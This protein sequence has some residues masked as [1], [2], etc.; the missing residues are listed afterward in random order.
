MENEFLVPGAT[1]VNE[2]ANEDQH[3]VPGDGLI[4]AD[5][6]APPPTPTG[7]RRPVIIAAG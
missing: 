5:V 6:A 3:L 1:I 7:R 4:D 2:T